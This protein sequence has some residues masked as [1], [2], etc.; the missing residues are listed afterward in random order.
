MSD[1]EIDAATASLLRELRQLSEG[2][3]YVS[4][5]DAPLEVVQYPAQGEKE[6]THAQLADW[7]GK[8]AGATV[9]K[10]ELPYF[11]RNMTKESEGATEEERR[12]A[13]RFQELQR[14]LEQHLQHVQVYRVGQRSITA[15]ILGEAPA[16]NLVGLK[17]ELVET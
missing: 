3:W 2:L 12:D 1:K 4:E 11:F 7:A 10:A 9:E 17:T 6:L 14:F 15:F 16:G 13:Q 8:P 5:T